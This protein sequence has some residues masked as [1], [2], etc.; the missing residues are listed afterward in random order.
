MLKCTV[1]LKI[2][3]LA[4]TPPKNHFTHLGHPSLPTNAITVAAATT[5][6]LPLT[7]NGVRRLQSEDD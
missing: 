5:V 7:A 1:Q 2:A 3:V 4:S 6:A